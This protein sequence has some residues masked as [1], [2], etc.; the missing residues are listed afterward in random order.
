MVAG[1]FYWRRRVRILVGR[2]GGSSYPRVNMHAHATMRHQKAIDG[3]Y[4]DTSVK[5][6]NGPSTMS[7]FFAFVFTSIRVRRLP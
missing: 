1:R 6:S 5:T 4:R 3:F 7:G 2:M